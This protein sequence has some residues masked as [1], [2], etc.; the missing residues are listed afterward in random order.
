MFR[1]KN[2]ISQYLEEF[3][4]RQ[5]GYDSCEAD[6]CIAYYCKNSPKEYKTILTN[7]KDL[8]QLSNESQEY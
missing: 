1:Q 7:D 2:R 5:G 4:I 8:L 6:D 3:F